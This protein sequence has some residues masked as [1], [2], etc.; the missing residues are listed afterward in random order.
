MGYVYTVAMAGHILS[1][2]VLQNLRNRKLKTQDQVGGRHKVPLCTDY[3]QIAYKRSI[4]AAVL[5]YIVSTVVT[6][7]TTHRKSCIIMHAGYFN[8]KINER[9]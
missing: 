3:T 1:Y 2:R 7:A 6:V 9:Q 4:S 5:H 8:S